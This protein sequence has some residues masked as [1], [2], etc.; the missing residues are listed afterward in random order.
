MESGRIQ[1]GNRVHL[2]SCCQLFQTQAVTVSLCHI[3][4][5]HVKGSKKYSEENL[6]MQVNKSNKQANIKHNLK[7]CIIIYIIMD[8]LAHAPVTMACDVAIQNYAFGH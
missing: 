3:K 8:F 4:L 1:S 7:N 5:T 2:K 6:T